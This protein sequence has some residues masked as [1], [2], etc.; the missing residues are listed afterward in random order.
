VAHEGGT[1]DAAS[2]LRPESVAAALL[3]AVTAGPDAHV[4]EVVVRPRG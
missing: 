1:Y 4:T 2:Y 3:A